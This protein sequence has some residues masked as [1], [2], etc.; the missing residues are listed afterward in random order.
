MIQANSPFAE[1]A[2]VRRPGVVADP[3]ER[4][5]AASE[6]FG[7]R[8]GEP[9]VRVVEA[10]RAQILLAGKVELQHS[11]EAL[12]GA[13]GIRVREH[14]DF[15]REPCE[16]SHHGAA[17]V[18]FHNQLGDEN[19]VR[20]VR[21]RVVESLACVHAPQRVQIGIGVGADTHSLEHAVTQERMRA[22]DCLGDIEGRGARGNSVRRERRLHGG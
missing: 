3:T 15:A 4:L 20:N 19:R 22:R 5:E 17:I 10:A 6:S 21:E 18:I 14:I 9:G 7:D 2:A 11:G 13:S 12:A 1:T 8:R 16:C